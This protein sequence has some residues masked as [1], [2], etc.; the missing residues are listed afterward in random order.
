M[1]ADLT[2]N[3]IVLKKAFDEKT[4]SERVST[5]RAINTPDKLVIKT[6]TYVDA[7]TKIA[8]TRHMARVDRWDVDDNSDRILT[9]IYVVCAIP[10]TAA[11]AQVSTTLATFKA[12]VAD[13]DFLAAVLNGEK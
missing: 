4:G 12:M 11:T 5:T 6:Q 9:S 1:N 10:E 2:F 7:A 8:G 3:S 13:A